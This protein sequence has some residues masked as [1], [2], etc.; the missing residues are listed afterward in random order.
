[1]GTTPGSGLPGSMTSLLRSRPA[2]LVAASLVVVAGGYGAASAV[3][4]AA[5]PGKV[6]V[7]VTKKNVVV[8]AT[9]AGKC[10]RGLTKVALSVQGPQGPPGPVGPVGPPGPQGP[11]GA[12]GTTAFGDGTQFGAPSTGA[13]CTIGEVI[14]SAGERAQGLPANG[15]LLDVVDHQ[16]LFSVL[17]YHYGTGDGGLKF[18]LPDLADAAPD[19]LTYSVCHQ[20]QF[21]GAL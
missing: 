7:C 12:T 4:A 13:T 9:D 17:G 14:L 8:S 5:G 11:V 16:A 21:P 2:A 10:P 3:Q 18:A 20:G 19:G 1:M 6:S 15:Q